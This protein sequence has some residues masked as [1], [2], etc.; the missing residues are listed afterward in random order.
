MTGFVCK[1]AFP[2]FPFVHCEIFNGSK[3][4]ASEVDEGF[5]Y[6]DVSFFFSAR[7]ASDVA[8][9]PLSIM[10]GPIRASYVPLAASVHTGDTAHC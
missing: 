10:F 5:T 4:V 9:L 3:F 1:C 2:N 7:I 8:F 6:T